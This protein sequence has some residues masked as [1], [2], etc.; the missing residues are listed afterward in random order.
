MKK[1]FSSSAILLLATM[2]NPGSLTAQKN[3]EPLFRDAPKIE[4]PANPGAEKVMVNSKALKSF[5][6]NF[7][8][9]AE[10]KWSTSGDMIQ[11]YYKE[12]GKQSRV[13]Y[14]PK[15]RWVRTIVTYDESQLN[16]YIKSLV[17]RDYWK[18]DISCVIEAREGAMHCYFINIETAKDFKQLIVYDG[19]VF[20]HQEFQKQ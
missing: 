6:R 19:E 18:Y 8:T 10:V 15:G 11:A 1:L 7:K 16:K 5:S 9:S 4:S 14:N 3:S 12:N 17:K 20:V 13:F 2:F